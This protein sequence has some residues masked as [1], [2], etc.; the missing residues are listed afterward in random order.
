MIIQGYVSVFNVRDAHSDTVSPVAFDKFMEKI[1]FS[2]QLIPLMVDHS[3]PYVGFVTE[4]E[5]HEK[6]G[7]WAVFKTFPS[8][9][10][11]IKDLFATQ[12]KIGL[13]IGYVTTESATTWAEAGEERILRGI[14]LKEV[15]LVSHPSNPK[16]WATVRDTSFSLKHFSMK[17]GTLS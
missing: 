8:Q 14:D 16:T 5:I 9:Q 3:P 11:Y 1:D 15:S 13:S 6:C 4:L 17:K 12:R 10:R 2:K 7:L